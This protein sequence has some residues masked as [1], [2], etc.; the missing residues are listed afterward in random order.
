M[1]IDADGTKHFTEA[2]KHSPGPYGKSGK[3]EIFKTQG[4]LRFWFDIDESCFLT[5]DPNIYIYHYRDAFIQTH[6]SAFFLHIRGR[7]ISFSK[8]M[9]ENG[10]FNDHIATRRDDGSYFWEIG[11]IGVLFR[12][13]GKAE[14]TKIALSNAQKF[15]SR[16][17]Q[18]FA[19]SFIIDALSRYSGEVL[20]MRLG[21]PQSADVSFSKKIKEKLANGDLIEGV[22]Q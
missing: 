1:I 16:E 21:E 10:F 20:G 5:D 2:D 12:N 11:G 15:R 18:D 17:E 8:T 6:R 4:G 22:E 19:I 14:R 7:T 3:E 9:K 13:P